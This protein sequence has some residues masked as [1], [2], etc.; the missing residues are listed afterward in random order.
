MNNLG[1]AI[2]LPG[3]YS[4]VWKTGLHKGKFPSLIQTGGPITVIRDND[5]DKYT[6][7]NTGVTETGFFGINLHPAGSTEKLEIGKWGAG[8]QVLS[9]P[10]EMNICM[11]LFFASANIWGNSFSYTLLREEDF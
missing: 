9:S 4:G 8:C 7:Y 3:Q 1:T 11:Q 10:H 6:D 5:F 2:V